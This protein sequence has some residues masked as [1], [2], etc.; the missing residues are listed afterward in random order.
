MSKTLWCVHIPEL[1]DF[2]ATV[3]EEA[4]VREA[5]AINA[6]REKFDNLPEGSTFAIARAWPFSETGHVRSLEVD[7]SDLQRMP[8]RSVSSTTKR[9]S[10]SSVMRWII[11]GWLR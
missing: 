3:S 9:R 4:A 2:I 8:H 6:Y 5:L 11:G 1:N 10:V 7:H